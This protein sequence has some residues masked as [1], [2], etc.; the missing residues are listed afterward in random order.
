[1]LTP[2]ILMAGIASGLFTP[3]VGVC[4][5]AAAQV[6]GLRVE[7]V[8]RGSLA[9]MSVLTIAILLLVLFSVLTVGPIRWLG[10]Y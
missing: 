6:S 1:M 9:P 8:I 7:D 5:F 10:L 2:V 3:T 4:L